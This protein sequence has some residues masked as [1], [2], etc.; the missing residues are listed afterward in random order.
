MKLILLYS[1]DGVE[2]STQNDLL[3]DVELIK[4]V[5]FF[6][7]HG[8]NKVRFTGGE[9]LVSCCVTIINFSKFFVR[10]GEM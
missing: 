8:V 2:L 7:Q 5:H 1:E 3:T 6:A 9:P 10:C 4:I